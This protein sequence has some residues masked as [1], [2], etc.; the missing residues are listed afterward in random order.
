[1]AALALASHVSA[2]RK[3]TST[4]RKSTAPPKTPARRFQGDAQ[5]QRDFARWVRISA[6]R[7][8]HL[9]NCR[10]LRDHGVFAEAK[11]ELAMAYE[12]NELA[13][14]LERAL[15]DLR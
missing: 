15:K 11:E 5:W 14:L 1:M 3:K 2:I 13:E 6:E 9:K 4:G 10:D 8:Q 12:D 7:D